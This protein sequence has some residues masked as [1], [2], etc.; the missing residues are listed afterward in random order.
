MLIPVDQSQRV[1]KPHEILLWKEATPPSPAF[2]KHT[3]VQGET[4]KY[5]RVVIQGHSKPLVLVGESNRCKAA[6]SD[7]LLPSGTVHQ[8]IRGSISK[9]TG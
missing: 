3:A 7:V 9:G 5:P 4:L 8:G 2:V 6:L 1:S